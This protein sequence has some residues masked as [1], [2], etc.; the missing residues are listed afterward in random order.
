MKISF[1]R[2]FVLLIIS[3]GMIVNLNC[4]SNPTNPAEAT[5]EEPSPKVFLEYV[6]RGGIGGIT[7]TLRIYNDNSV[8]FENQEFDIQSTLSQNIINHILITLQY[9]NF[10]SLDEYYEST[11][12]M[13]AFV[14]KITY[15]SQVKSNT[16]TMYGHSEYFS[17]ISNIV[18]EL[19]IIIENLKENVD[20]GKVCLKEKILIE[21]WPFSDI[22]KLSDYNYERVYVSEEIFNHFK[23]YYLSDK[24]VM[25]FE[26]DLLYEINSSGGYSKTYS[27]LS[28][29]FYLRIK[30][31]IRPVKWPESLNIPLNEISEEGVFVSDSSFNI[32]EDLLDNKNWPYYYVDE[33]IKTGNYV[34]ELGLIKGDG[35]K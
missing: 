23:D 13:D 26:G 22:V 8:T 14:Y 15:I 16:V 7:E 29:G 33:D 25:Y 17:F 34:Y 6:L 4:T 21:E 10:L 9:Y 5:D 18:N 30:K 31:G 32:T 27:E 1:V 19:E 2:K 28:S 24:K 12:I 11:V 20:C 3:V 35:F